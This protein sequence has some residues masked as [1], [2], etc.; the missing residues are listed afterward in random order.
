MQEFQLSSLVFDMGIGAFLGFVSG[1]AAKIVLKIFLILA[2]VYV[3][4]LLYLQQRD[5]ISINQENLG[6]AIPSLQLGGILQSLAG[7]LPMGGG[8]LAGFY[9]GF[10][11]AG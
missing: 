9:L 8:F 5:I 2:G 11:R 3:A 4:S 1:Y 10:R 6:K 7:A